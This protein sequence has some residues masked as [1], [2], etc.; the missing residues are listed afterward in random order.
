MSP[1]PFLCSDALRA[2]PAVAAVPVGLRGG[3]LRR[4]GADAGDHHILLHLHHPGFHGG[5]IPGTIF[6]ALL[7]YDETPLENC[8][9]NGYDN[10]FKTRFI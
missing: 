4:Q 1:F 7:T 10:V 9:A 2:V 8:F 3:G 6:N 5:A